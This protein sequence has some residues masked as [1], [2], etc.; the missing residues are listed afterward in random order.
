LCI[1]GCSISLI[2]SCA[3]YKYKKRFANNSFEVVSDNESNFKVINSKSKNNHYESNNGKATIEL[4]SLK[5]SELNFYATNPI[6]D[7]IPIK[8]ERTVRPDALTKDIALGVFTFGVPVI[9]DV[10]KS[11][12]YKI[13]K[14]TK[15]INIHF[16]YKQSFMTEEFNKIASSINP[17]DYKIWIEK[18][19]KSNLIQKATDRKDSLELLIALSKESEKAI[20]DFIV[21]HEKSSFLDESLKIKNEM[22]A[23]REL[24]DA[25]KN[26]NTVES[27]EAFLSKFPKSLHN[28]E[29]HRKLVEAAEKA[30]IN[31]SSTTLMVNY[32]KNYLINNLSFF[33]SDEIAEK[34]SK[35][36]NSLDEQLIKDYI[37]ND[38]KKI[39]QNYSDLWKK[40][41]EIKSDKL[42]ND[43]W[44]GLYRTRQY[45]TKI[46]DLIFN[47]LKESKSI[48]TQ[49]QI[50]D[51]CE[52]DFPNLGI[53]D[54]FNNLIYT[55][56]FFSKGTGSIKLFN[57][58]YVPYLFNLGEYSSFFDNIMYSYK[59]DQYK[60]LQNITLEELNFLNGSFHGL[61]KCYNSS[62]L[63]F[64]FNA[65]Q[66]NSKDFSYFQNG[67]LVKTK[68]R[69]NDGKFY[70]YE[71]ENGINLTLKELDK[72][73]EK[74]KEY[75]KSGNYDLAISEF[76]NALKN[77]FP[78]SIA[79]NINLN[80]NLLNVKKLN[81]NKISQNSIEN[82]IDNSS[83]YLPI[84][85][86]NSYDS[87]KYKVVKIG[88]YEWSSTNLDVTNFRN[89]DPIL[90][91]K[92][93]AEIV[94]AA[95]NKIPAYTI[96]PYTGNK[97][98]NWYAVNDL[99]A[100]APKGFAVSEYKHFK[101]LFQ[102]VKDRK[103]ILK[104][105][106]WGKIETTD[107]YGL[108]LAPN[109]Y[110]VYN[111]HA[112]N[113]SFYGGFESNYWISDVEIDY[114]KLKAE[115]GYDP[116]HSW[117][118]CNGCYTDGYSKN[119][120]GS[121]LAVRC[122]R[123]KTNTYYGEIKDGKPNGMGQIIIEKAMNIGGVNN[124]KGLVLGPGESYKGYWKNGVPH[125]A[126][127]LN[128]IS[129]SINKIVVDS[130]LFKEG[131]YFGFWSY[132]KNSQQKCI[133][134]GIK[135]TRCVLKTQAQIKIDKD[136]G[137]IYQDPEIK[138]Y[139]C[140]MYCS[141]KCENN[142]K[143]KAELNRIAWQNAHSND[144]KNSSIEQSTSTKSKSDKHVWVCDDCGKVQ[145]SKDKPFDKS[146]CPETRW[147]GIGGAG[148]IFDDGDH[149]YTNLGNS[150][151]IQFVC[152]RC[153]ISIMLFEKPKY[154]GTCGASGSNCC[155]HNWKKN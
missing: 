141:E 78:T 136:N 34:K 72:K 103:D 94:A 37:T 127:T 65:F 86:D 14:S 112:E 15:K 45:H 146:T 49:N 126:G 116:A 91:V 44:Y 4:S 6:Y 133:E 9:I 52:S 21:T 32:I 38:T 13:S 106:S 124:K 132:I 95:L 93:D 17:S 109:A 20:D 68:T 118:I 117:K 119:D 125:G 83:K 122:V 70:E 96:D 123:G 16:E 64:T 12:F 33:I 56:L 145:V 3:S 29:A 148:N 60:S 25:A 76:E 92:T 51:K 7:S 147:G 30:A 113:S 28:K 46:C 150:G 19:P 121:L 63:D 142:A 35:I 67:K 97:L 1:L 84:Q 69:L 134:C 120:K 151:S 153:N 107:K 129:Y 58:G 55:V 50:V 48:E 102:S 104:I 43:Y 11:D 131:N 139:D 149:N 138:L 90:F 59:G 82:T 47:K 22:V 88:Q 77:N 100:L 39:Y 130:S 40:Y 105:G 18:Y 31:S 36:L 66:G 110:C 62:N 85:I 24:F 5:K 115:K 137:F 114:I 71:F 98:Y 10:F 74:G 73:I 61:N 54:N 81:E 143:Q 87:T 108:S 111:G 79:Q 8:I 154:E 75:I 152:S 135:N 99:R 140:E 41:D 2:N 155:S 128:R 89:G 101:D 57:V 80:K 53:N 42:L 26:Q 27:Y 144:S 23:A